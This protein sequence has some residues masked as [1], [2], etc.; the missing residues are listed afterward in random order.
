MRGKEIKVPAGY[1]GVIITERD[2]EKLGGK[3]I[4]KQDVNKRDGLEEE[5]D[6]KVLQELGSFDELVLWG[7]ESIVEG[8]D[9]FV[10]G[11]EEWIGFA[12][13]VSFTVIAAR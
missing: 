2:E 1:K 8:E 3:T 7:H 10:K 5:N 12:E 4:D 11:M 13:A 9:T 6:V